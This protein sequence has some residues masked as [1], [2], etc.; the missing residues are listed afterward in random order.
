MSRLSA[1]VACP[2]RLISIVSRQ[3]EARVW[4]M[5]GARK[6]RAMA[7][8]LMGLIFLVVGVAVIGGVA[9]ILAGRWRDGLPEV[10]PDGEAQVEIGIDVPVGDLTVTDIEAIRLE[11][12]PRGYRMDDV[13]QLVDRLA[14]EIEAR[15][16]EIAR[17]RGL[18]RHEG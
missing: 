17:L 12:A 9:L 6:D 2:C 7:G 13:D 16:E 1:L 5:F 14:Q 10:R 15:D 11:Q 3:C 8:G 18:P 4:V